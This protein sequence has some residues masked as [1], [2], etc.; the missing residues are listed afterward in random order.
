MNTENRPETDQVDKD[1]KTPKMELD[2]SKICRDPSVYLLILGN[3]IT[4]LFYFI[5]SWNVATLVIVIFIQSF[6]NIVFFTFS[7]LFVKDFPQGGM[8]LESK[9]GKVYTKSNL[10]LR[11]CLGIFFFGCF[12]LMFL[13]A[14]VIL[15]DLR[16]DFNSI[17]KIA[18]LFIISQSIISF[19]DLKKPFMEYYKS[20]GLNMAHSVI[21]SVATLAL[22]MLIF[23]PYLGVVILLSL[24][25][26]IDIVFQSLKNNP[27]FKIK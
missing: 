19:R 11:G 13:G 17:M 20:S 16:P 1:S 10:F 27:E 4:L 6:L 21:L 24:K 25:S 12:Y 3:L 23:I 14:I 2:W 7:Y 9:P 26:Y 5:Y 8:T 18:P 15:F 22:S